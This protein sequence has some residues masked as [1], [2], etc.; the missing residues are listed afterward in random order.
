MSISKRRKL[1]VFASLAAFGTLITTQWALLRPAFPGL[2]EQPEAKATLGAQNA[3]ATA[4]T[5]VPSERT[6]DG[7]GLLNA[8]DPSPALDS[9]PT[10]IVTETA[11]GATR[12]RVHHMIEEVCLDKSDPGR[13]ER[14]AQEEQQ[15]RRAAADA[16][17]KEVEAAVVE[18]D[19]RANAQI[20]VALVNT[21][22]RLV[23]VFRQREALLTKMQAAQRNAAAATQAQAD[24]QREQARAEEDAQ[25]QAW[26][27]AGQRA[28]TRPEERP[29]YSLASDLSKKS[30]AESRA[31][32]AVEQAV[33]EARREERNNA[34]ARATGGAVIHSS[35][36]SHEFHGGAT[37]AR[38][39]GAVEAARREER[40]N[41]R[42]KAFGGAVIHSS[43]GLLDRGW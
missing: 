18:A 28:Q 24:R 43:S 20:E 25:Q 26:R 37:E 29:S 6:D 32:E 8:V 12:A 34:R 38:I 11:A 21:R 1:V 30:E 17:Y 27:L 16:Y 10:T 13:T 15:A 31:R 5:H 19:A 42:A 2:D 35:S 3:A 4:P 33:E 39:N 14:R 7:V 9:G 41:E 36:F 22:G 23:D 40:N